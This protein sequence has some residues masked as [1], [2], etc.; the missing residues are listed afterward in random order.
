MDYSKSHDY[1]MPMPDDYKYIWA[2]GKMSGSMDYYI[3]QQI[4][5]ARGEN[6]PLD[7][8]Y[9]DKTWGKW[10]TVGNVASPTCALIEHII[11]ERGM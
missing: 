1:K 6:A 8:I 2:W 9:Y 7:A 11:N 10:H 4:K 3:D 5:K